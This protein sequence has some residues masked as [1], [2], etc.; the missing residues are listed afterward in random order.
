[1]ESRMTRVK[2]AAGTFVLERATGFEP[3]TKSLGSMLNA[4]GRHRLSAPREQIS[5]RDC[6][7]ASGAVRQPSAWTPDGH[8]RWRILMLKHVLG[9]V[10]LSRRRGP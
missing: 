4:P 5:V 8:P 9:K 1:M 7:E 10:L 2:R 6:P 3:A